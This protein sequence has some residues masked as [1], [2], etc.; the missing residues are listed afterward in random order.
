MMQD[1]FDRNVKTQV[2]SEQFENYTQGVLDLK[3]KLMEQSAMSDQVLDSIA[4]RMGEI[5][6]I[7]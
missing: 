1:N 7:S 2:I 5:K 3:A 4:S 6:P